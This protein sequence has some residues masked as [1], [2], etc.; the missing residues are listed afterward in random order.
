MDKMMK[1]CTKPHPLLHSVAGIGIGFLLVALFGSTL[2][3]K[4]MVLGIILLVVGVA[5]E[6]VFLKK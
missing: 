1:E 6:F 4:A 5:G 2:I 3:A